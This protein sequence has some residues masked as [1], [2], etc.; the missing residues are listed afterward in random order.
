MRGMAYLLVHTGSKSAPPFVAHRGA[1]GGGDA[2]WVYVLKQH[3]PH[4]VLVLTH[5]QL[6]IAS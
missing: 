6:Y 2:A 4:I 5:V 1:S 3:V